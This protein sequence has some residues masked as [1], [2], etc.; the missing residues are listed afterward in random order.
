VPRRAL[1]AAGVLCFALVAPE[2]AAAAL[3][4]VAT[5]TPGLG[6]APL[7][8]SFDAGG[9][10]AGSGRT[11]VAWAWDFG[12]GAS[13]SGDVVTHE[14]SGPGFYTATL[15]VT[16]D[17]GATHSAQVEVLAQALTLSLAPRSLV[18][19]RAVTA[20]GALSPA[21]AGVTVVVERRTGGGW[22]VLAT[23]TTDA[24]GH[25]AAAFV[26]TAGGVVRARVP[27]TGAASPDRALAVLPRLVV[28]R[29]P[30]RAFLGAL[31]VAEVRPLAYT[32]RVTATT[33]RAG[34]VL[35][36]V[37]VRVRNGRLRV[38]VPTPGV[39]RFAVRLRFPAS[40]GLSPRRLS[41]SVRAKA[42]TLS[43]GSR[44]RDVRALLRRLAELH[45]HVPGLSTTFGWATYDA[46]IAF[47]KAT[48]LP[49][50][51]VVGTATWQALGRARVLRPRYTRPWLHIEIDKT[52][53]IVLLV[54]GGRVGAV[55]PTSTGAT[56][57]TPLG[58]WRIYYKAPG[59]NAVGMYYSL[60]FLRGF[61]VHGYHS[62]P[63]WPASHGCARIP[64]WS[65]YWLY[66]RSSVGE[67]VYVYL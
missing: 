36:R 22:Q 31:L 24:A 43:V 34:R 15:T 30:G 2:T 37:R 45:Y 58:A 41:T 27:G 29:R 61:A 55:F 32:G 51:G 17:L 20:S 54:R 50:T 67:R 4:A 57:N 39:G 33:R 3:G 53:Q 8:V 6:P 7:A 64:I 11:I 65:A 38:L 49:R 1:A 66:R 12:D 13:G 46:V 63:P 28:H 21:E 59:Y 40:A 62:V 42:R 9:S 26:P 56:G 5:A 44:G 23:T 10:T 14:Y 48:R 35:G 60:F 19:G 47:Q 52:R 16:D 25:F 18:F